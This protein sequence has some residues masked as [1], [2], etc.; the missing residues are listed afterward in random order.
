MTTQ[1]AQAQATLI[2]QEA[3]AK[4]IVAMKEAEA[5]GIL[6]TQSAQAKGIQAKLE[7]QAEG[8]SKFLTA[9][10]PELV[11]A[12]RLLLLRFLDAILP[13]TFPA[14]CCVHTLHFT[15]VHASL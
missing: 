11:R 4:G 3:Q 1:E 5:Q 14:A 12:P 13:C 9:A 15:I 6:A 8:L 7:A 2:M 10:D